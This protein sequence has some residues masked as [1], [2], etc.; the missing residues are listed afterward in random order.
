MPKQQIN[1]GRNWYVIHTY[2][3]YEDAVARNLKQRI[4]ALGMQDKI[5]NVLVPKEKKIK[6]K[7]GK[8]AVIEEKIY[9]G[10]VFVDML[11]TDDSWYVVRNTPM[12]TGFIGAGT[13]PRPVQDEEIK[14]ILR[15]I[16]EEEPKYKIEFGVGDLVKIMDGPFKN[17][18]GKV[19]EIDKERGRVKVSVS[20]FGRDTPI[21]L[22]FL[23]VKKD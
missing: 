11:V 13:T 20:L 18:E 16:V 15:K 12:V 22:D 10:Y 5:F 7:N 19:Q 3:G 2:S 6:I 9:P 17:S 14:E 21:D 1:L 23:Q 8:R 4:E